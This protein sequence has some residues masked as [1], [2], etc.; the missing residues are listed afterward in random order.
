MNVPLPMSA[1]PVGSNAGKQAGFVM[2]VLVG[3]AFYMAARANASEPKKPNAPQ[4]R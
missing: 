3:L 1:F 2:A 4:Q